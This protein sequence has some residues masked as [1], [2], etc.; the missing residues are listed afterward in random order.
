ML[1]KIV[2]CSTS[3]SSSLDI[4]N[5]RSSNAGFKSIEQNVFLIRTVHIAFHVAVLSVDKPLDDTFHK[6]Y[7]YAAG[8]STIDC[9]NNNKW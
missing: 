4:V 5:S 3:F 1:G 6:K 7:P 2:L 9:Q 8:L